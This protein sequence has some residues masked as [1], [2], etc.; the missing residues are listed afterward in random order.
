LRWN[1]Q[2]GS[3]SRPSA[4]AFHPAIVSGVLFRGT[5]SCGQLKPALTPEHDVHQHNLRPQLLCPPQRLSRGSGNADDAQALPFQA[6]AGGLHEQPA[7][8]HNQD[9]EPRHVNSVPACTVP[10]IGASRDRKSRDLSADPVPGKDIPA[11]GTIMSA[12]QAGRTVEPTADAG[13]QRS[14]RP[15][16]PIALDGLAADALAG[17]ENVIVVPDRVE[18][19]RGAEA[20]DVLIREA[21]GKPGCPHTV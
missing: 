2:H 4:T 14:S 3:L 10:R 17:Y 19:R 15:A 16:V 20:G 18:I 9:T 21:G 1:A 7:V 13:S 6:I 12:L 5:S 11:A 8:V